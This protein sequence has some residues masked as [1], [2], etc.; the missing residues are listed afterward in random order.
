MVSLCLAQQLDKTSMAMIIQ[1][2]HKPYYNHAIFLGN[3]LFSAL[4]CWGISG[5]TPRFH[6]ILLLWLLINCL[7]LKPWVF[8]CF[9]PLI[10]AWILF[11]PIGLQ[12]GYPNVG[13]IASLLQTNI[14]EATEF[15]DGYTILSFII[16]FILSGIVFFLT[17]RIK[18]T[19]KQQRFFKIFAYVLSTLFVVNIFSIKH[20]TLRIDYSELLNIFPHSLH[21]YHIYHNNQQK[22]QEMLSKQ[23]TWQ[24]IHFEPRYQN[25][26]IVMGESASKDYL[27]AY[28]YP[29]KTSPFLEHVNGTKY[30]QLIA[31]AAYTTLSIPR[32]FSIP[33]ASEVE[34]HNNIITLAKKANMQTFWISN[35]DKLGE[36][37]NEV[38]YI[39]N[40][41]NH[42]Y[43]L[44][45]VK[46]TGNHYDYELLEEINRV[47]AKPSSQPKLIIVHLMGSHARFARRVDDNRPKFNFQD[48]HLSDYLSSLLQTDI[49]LQELYTG[50]QNNKQPF[51]MIYLS[52]HGLTPQEL[53]HGLSQFSLQVPLFKL[54]SDDT[55]QKTDDNVIT[56]FGFVWFLSDWLGVKTANQASNTFINS[57]QAQSLSVVKVFS[58][59]VNNYNEIEKTNKPI[60]KPTSTELSNPNQ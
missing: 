50:L 54:S 10:L 47:I 9:L 46:P 36:H 18:S 2:T 4:L 12:Y 45:E 60:L 28:G 15:A 8:R 25:Y 35:Q 29:V 52:D 38:A 24:I 11:A 34:Y 58:D 41:A 33:N 1:L 17:K 43:Y 19:A 49:F 3:F 40:H 27:S 5:A 51:S 37:E 7:W 44:K 56:G 23:D 59:K 21:Q 16:V 57:Y 31:P 30:T 55:Q 22:M 42:H 53:K 26:V 32:F 20:Q 14:N 48:G 39:A 13:M 6:D